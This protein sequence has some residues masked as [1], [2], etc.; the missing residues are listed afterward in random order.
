APPRRDKGDE[1]F[2]GISLAALLRGK[3]KELPDRQL[4]VQYGHIF[5]KFDSCVIWGRWRLV[6][7]EELY[8]VEADLAQKANLA[9]QHPAVVKAM[10]G[11]YERWWKGVEPM[12]N[13]FVAS[14]IGA[15]Q[16]PVVELTSSD[17]EGVHADDTAWIRE[18]VGG[19]TGGHWNLLVEQAGEYE[20]T[21]R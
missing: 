7:G 11:H 1:L 4:V 8:D 18:T 9:G 16:Q 6:K 13:D 21:L 10:R 15:R 19:P 17:W 14:S 5:K 20:L 12:R 3:Q 2:A